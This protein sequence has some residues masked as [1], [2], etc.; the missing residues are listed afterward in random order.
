VDPFFP[1]LLPATI[2]LAVAS[3][4]AMMHGDDEA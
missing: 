4:G 1:E 3:I 2:K